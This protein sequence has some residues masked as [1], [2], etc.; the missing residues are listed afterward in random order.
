VVT[1]PPP[2]AVEGVWESAG[3]IAWQHDRWVT[4]TP[5]TLDLR[6]DREA[7][8]RLATWCAGLG[9]ERLASQGPGLFAFNVFA[10]SAE[11]GERLGELQR[12]YFTQ[13][14]SVIAESRPATRI[15]VTNLQLFELGSSE[16]EDRH[17]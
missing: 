1:R 13:L 10:V 8:L 6:E 9:A 4:R 2:A 3:Q 11:D 16:S 14:R 5:S 12:Q 15:F 7:T 17:P